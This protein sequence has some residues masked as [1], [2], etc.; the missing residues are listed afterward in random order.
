MRWES[1]G[2]LGCTLSAPEFRVH[3]HK[4][5]AFGISGENWVMSTNGLL[6]FKEIGLG[7]TDLVLAKKNAISYLRKIAA[8]FYLILD[9]FEKDISG[10]KEVEM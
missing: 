1:F 6:E 10:E 2:E 7:T 5:K 4:Q 9:K 8:E 3:I